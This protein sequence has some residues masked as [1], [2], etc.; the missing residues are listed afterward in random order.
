MEIPQM[1]PEQRKKLEEWN[2]KWHE[3]NEK[4]RGEAKEQFIIDHMDKV[5]DQGFKW[6]GE[7]GSRYEE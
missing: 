1:S 5:E 3:A 6:G 4:Y 7:R 2:R